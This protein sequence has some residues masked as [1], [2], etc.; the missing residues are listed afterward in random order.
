MPGLMPPLT[1]RAT[2][3]EERTEVPLDGRCLFVSQDSTSP[4]LHG[5][6]TAHRV[7]HRVATSRAPRPCILLEIL[8]LQRACDEL[9]ERRDDAALPAER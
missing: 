9:I 2:F 4:L 5:F 7:D 3:F 6:G 1:M 8:G